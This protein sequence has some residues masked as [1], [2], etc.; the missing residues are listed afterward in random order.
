MLSNFYLSRTDADGSVLGLSLLSNRRAAAAGIA[1]S[2]A[3]GYFLYRAAPCDPDSVEI[4][5][6]VESDEAALRLK[7]LLN[8]E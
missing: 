5:A 6:R 2:D 7:S 4:I 8:L 1:P 3:R